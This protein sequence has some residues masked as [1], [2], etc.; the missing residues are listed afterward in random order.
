MLQQCS[1]YSATFTQLLSRSSI[2]TTLMQA[3]HTAQHLSWQAHTVSLFC[4][5]H[6][7]ALVLQPELSC[8]SIYA[9][10]CTQ[11]HFL[12][13]A[14]TLSF[15][16]ASIFTVASSLALL[17]CTSAFMLQLLRG[18]SA[19]GQGPLGEHFP[20]KSKTHAGWSRGWSTEQFG[21]HIAT[22]SAPESRP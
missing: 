2:H 12:V 7:T 17:M 21:V 3:H 8:C 20:T 16:H 4:P 22:H 5:S 11:Q 10:P 9:A 1:I 19:G 6:A 18:H 13:A 14:F 15:S